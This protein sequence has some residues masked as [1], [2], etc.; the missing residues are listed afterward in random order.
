MIL[1]NKRAGRAAALLA[2]LALAAGCGQRSS[3]VLEKPLRNVVKTESNAMTLMV[4]TDAGV[5]AG[6]LVHIDG[7][8]DLAVFPTS[9]HETIENTADHL[10]RKN[11][12]VINRIA[13][14]IENGGTVNLGVKSGMFR[15]VIWVIPS[16]GSVTDLP[17]ENFRQALMLKRGFPEQALGDLAVS[18]RHITGTIAGV[19]LTVTSLEDLDDVEE[20]ALLDI[21]LSY[22]A[23]LQA[24]SPD[25]K[26]G[27]SSLLNFLRVLKRKRI[28]AVMATINRSSINQAAP[29]DTRYF[30][31][32][33]EETL[34]DPSLLEGP[35]PE[36]YKLMIQAE[37]ALAAGN[38]SEASAVYAGL[39]KSYPQDAGL[40]FSHAIALGFLDKGEECREEML[41]A[42]AIDSTYM[43]GFFQL[44]RVLGA[45]GRVS[46]GEALLETSDLN[47][48]LP[49]IE[50]DY[51]RG[52]FYAQAGLHVQ[53]A[54]I[55]VN[56]A[57]KRPKDFAIR[58][59]LYKSYEQLD[60]TRRMYSTLEDLVQLDRG[61]VTRDM[62]W[63]FKKLGDLAWNFH[64]DLFAAGWY[65]QYLAVVHDDPDSTRM[66]EIVKRWEGVDKTPRTMK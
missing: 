9:L 46:A 30:A 37:S 66:R 60:D 28:H 12:S 44:A 41:N 42:Y 57:A 1:I 43:K 61:R 59:V 22:F 27:T 11:S 32:I 17:L 34:R 51:Q 33:I 5:K 36:K 23:G 49:E 64:M 48:T 29:L 24:V 19:P 18:G 50:M 40:R 65:E 8:D 35:L 3:I 45:N 58:T 10:E 25:Y 20:T 52:L 14:I 38:Y 53:A 21:D 6:V 16:R 2:A 63:A 4:W 31:D 15:R 7:T 47:K 55:L 39:V 13:T 26:P 54:E 62:P 56:V